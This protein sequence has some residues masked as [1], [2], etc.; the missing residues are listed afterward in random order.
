M[1]SD[2]PSAIVAS[3][4]RC[5]RGDGFIDTFYRLFLASSDEVR[6]KFQ[7]TDMVHQKLV[8]RESL[9]M[10]ILYSENQ[11][12]SQAEL[13]KLAERHDRN[14]ADIAPHLYELWLDTLCI[15]VAQHDPEFTPQVEQLW[16]D[17]MQPGIDLMI[18]RY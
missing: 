13:I 5:M 17:A 16:R 11:D 14:H 6:I 3:Y 8:L 1:N 4:R 12:R 10:L 2:T 9:L 18:S 15:A 7:F